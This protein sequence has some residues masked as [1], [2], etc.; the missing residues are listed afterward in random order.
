MER[1]VSKKHVYVFEMDKD[2]SKSEMQNQTQ[3]TG[4]TK[5]LRQFTAM[6]F[7]LQDKEW[8]LIEKFYKNNQQLIKKRFL[9]YV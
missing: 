1:I 8:N 9:K 5:T 4:S 7:I 2:K 6:I 3:A